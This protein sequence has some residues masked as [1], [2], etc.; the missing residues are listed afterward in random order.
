MAK[1][2][3]IQSLILCVCLMLTAFSG[4]SAFAADPFALVSW[5]ADSDFITLD[6][7]QDIDVSTADITLTKDGL[8]VPFTFTKNDYSNKVQTANDSN[9]N[10]VARYFTYFVTPTGG[11]DIDEVYTLTVNAIENADGTEAITPITKT[12]T[13]KD[14]GGELTNYREVGVEAGKVAYNTSV[15]GQV[16]ASLTV[17][18]TSYG[19]ANNA[20]IGTQVGKDY[21]NS[22]PMTNGSTSNELWTEKDYTIKLNIKIE[23]ATKENIYFGIADNTNRV[24]Y[25][26]F[27]GTYMYMQR[28]N[29]TDP[30]FY[31]RE[32][33][34]TANSTYT[35]NAKLDG[36]NRPQG[37]DYTDLDLKFSTRDQIAHA[38]VE[39]KKTA[40][41]YLS[42]DAMGWAFV[43]IEAITKASGSNVLVATVSDFL[44]TRCYEVCSTEIDKTADVEIEDDITITFGQDVDTATMSN[45]KLVDGEGV[46]VENYSVTPVSSTEA[47]VEFTGLE[48]RSEYTLEFDGV[49][50]L[51]D[52]EYVAMDNQSFTTVVP[53][54][55]LASFGITDGEFGGTVSLEAVIAN[56]TQVED[57]DFIATIAIYNSL[58]EMVKIAGDTYSL[59]TGEDAT[60]TVADF[61]C[62]PE[63][64]YT[65][66]CFV[67]DSFTGMNTIFE[68]II[69]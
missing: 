63:E 42:E 50:T 66:K 25:K 24:G 28:Q 37:M 19:E 33:R 38:F 35:Y 52:I 8:D 15:P 58:G 55:E 1:Y 6:F 17:F 18:T 34:S 48:Y 32:D 31:F 47:L 56:N 10:D 57:L 45:I 69:E 68:G 27:T 49:E 46:E 26:N 3:K 44:A 20:Y 67:W 62:D 36:G 16:S 54:I 64:T 30:N 41:L 7:N 13:V 22:V 12:F 14:L 43:S 40:D 39:G 5:N 53:P 4:I 59:A 21:E 29:E 9:T 23:G 2:L 65:A 11:I 51:A 61:V 60:V